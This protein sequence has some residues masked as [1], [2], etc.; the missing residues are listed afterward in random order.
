MYGA[1]ST[2]LVER[3]KKKRRKN[4]IRP[5]P[6]VTADFRER[7]AFRS[8]FNLIANRRSDEISSL[9]C[10]SSMGIS[11]TNG[12]YG[13]CTAQVSNYIEK[14]DSRKLEHTKRLFLPE[15]VL[16]TYISNS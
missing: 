1:A 14:T 11:Q 3:R 12:L 15:H 16:S 13:V 10:I 5:W 7:M 4:A 8:C 6:A 2:A 9:S